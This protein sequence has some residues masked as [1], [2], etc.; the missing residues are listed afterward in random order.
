M[1]LFSSYSIL[2][3]LLSTLFFSC[4]EDIQVSFAINNEKNLVSSVDEPAI[5]DL[6]T[7]HQIDRDISAIVV[8]ASTPRSAIES[9]KW[10]LINQGKVTDLQKDSA[11][12]HLSFDE[13]GVYGLT[14][15]LNGD[16]LNSITHWLDVKVSGS[17]ELLSDEVEFDENL[18]QAANFNF[19]RSQENEIV[20]EKSYELIINA[21]IY[22]ADFDKISL[23]FNGRTQ[24]AEFDPAMGV[25]STVV[26]LKKGEN[27]FKL[28][29]DEFEIEKIVTYSLN[30]PKEEKESPKS[31][32]AEAKTDERSVSGGSQKSVESTGGNTNDKSV[33][34]SENRNDKNLPVSGGG[35]SEKPKESVAENNSNKNV[36]KTGDGDAKKPKEIASEIEKTKDVPNIG[37]GGKNKAKETV[38]EVK[39]DTKIPNPVEKTPPPPPPPANPI[40]YNLSKVEPSCMEALGSEYSFTIKPTFNAE[41]E[42][43]TIF[44]DVCGGINLELSSK[45]G[46]EKEV[47]PLN[48]GKNQISLIGLYPELKA[49]VTYTLKLKTIAAYGNCSATSVPI[50]QKA[51]SSC[52]QIQ[53]SSNASITVD[54]KGKAAIFN[55]QYHYSK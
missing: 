13:S 34:T 52:S 16:A 19:I 49:G 1:K 22:E 37:L 24:K 55:L 50:I 18:L 4:A 51:K 46:T 10:L 38:A 41:L 11:I 12:I 27:T 8:D 20:Y 53:K 3:L 45:N 31:P 35:D 2:L 36:Q 32:I 5:A 30:R 17:R 21:D 15:Q 42:E 44:T 14:L 54:Y 43:M 47:Q 48:P 28:K 6:Y 25:I 40:G 9:R 26:N 7:V 29:S 33:S 23:K 39:K